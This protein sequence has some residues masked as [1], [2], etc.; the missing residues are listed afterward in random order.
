M[1]M[2]MKDDNSIIYREW[3]PNAV[4]ASLIGE[5]SMLHHRL[6]CILNS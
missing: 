4:S 3:A 5:F 2:H 1:G 6:Q